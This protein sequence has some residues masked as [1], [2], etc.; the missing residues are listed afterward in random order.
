[1]SIASILSF[2][3]GAFKWQHR[4]GGFEVQQSQILIGELMDK[5]WWA[6]FCING[7]TNQFLALLY[8]KSP[9][10]VLPFKC[11]DLEI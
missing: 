1:M 4:L 6:P 3:A 10:T 5:K 11:T 9:K 2:Q 8:L 7:K